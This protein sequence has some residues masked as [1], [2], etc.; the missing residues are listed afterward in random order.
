MH[1]SLETL[2]GRVGHVGVE[3]RWRELARGLTVAL[4]YPDDPRVCCEALFVRPLGDGGYHIL[5][6]AVDGFLEDATCESG[7]RLSHAVLY[8]RDSHFPT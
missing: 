2:R 6:P 7:G 1:G 8:Q 3:E 5:T 4:L